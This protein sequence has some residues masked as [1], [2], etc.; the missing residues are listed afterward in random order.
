MPFTCGVGD[1][2]FKVDYGDRHR[3]VVISKP[4]ADGKVVLV[5]FTRVTPYKECVVIFKPEDDKEL[6]RIPTT[7][8]Y[9]NAALAS[10]SNV[11][12]Y[13]DNGYKCCKAIH[14]EKIIKGAFQ[15]EF[16]S[17]EIIDELK[18]QYPIEYEKYYPKEDRV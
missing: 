18:V 11:A 1:S 13:G 6:F 12:K 17:P 14:I 2:F 10:T 15:S 5:N 3:Y 4:N 16:I 9:R 7:I 8:N